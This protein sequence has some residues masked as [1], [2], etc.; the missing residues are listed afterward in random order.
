MTRVL[1]LVLAA[2]LAVGV[3]VAVA[4]QVSGRFAAPS[5]QTVRGVIGSEKLAFF[6][7]PDVQTA[8]RKNGL[9]VQVDTAGSREMATTVGAIYNLHYR[10]NQLL[11]ECLQKGV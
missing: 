1:G 6:Q 5:V 7:D 9:D 8:F 2:V 3:V 4:I 10:A 11:R